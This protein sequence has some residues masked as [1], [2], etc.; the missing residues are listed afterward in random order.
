MMD[1]L[2]ELNAILAL[3]TVA[4]GGAKRAVEALHRVQSKA[5]FIILGSFPIG[6]G[7]GSLYAAVHDFPPSPFVPYFTCCFIALGALEIW[8]P[9]ALRYPIPR[10]ENSDELPG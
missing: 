3:L 7:L 8:W 5:M 9:P 1:L 10:Q 4:L 2:R 6:V